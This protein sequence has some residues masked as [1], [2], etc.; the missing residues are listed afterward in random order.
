MQVAASDCKVRVN[1]FRKEL[2]KS[3]S[4]RQKPI[5]FSGSGVSQGYHLMASL[6]LFMLPPEI[7]CGLSL[8]MLRLRQTLAAGLACLMMA[9]CG[10]A[11]AVPGELP[12]LGDAAQDVLSPQMQRRLGESFYN[13][14]RLRDPAYIDDPEIT[15]YVSQVGRRLVSA[16]QNPSG[17]FTFFVLRDRQINAFATFGGYVGINTGLLLA[18]RTESE[19][20]GVLAHEISHVNQQHLARGI[21]AAK[22]QSISSLA[23]LALMILAVR[24]GQAGQ[25]AQGA[26]AAIEAANIQSQLGYSRDFEREADRVGFQTLSK[27]G[28]D[29]RGMADFFERLQKS[30]ALY[31]NNAPVYLR[32]HPLTTERI[33]DMQGRAQGAPYRQVRDSLDFYLVRAKLRTLEYA[34]QD[35]LAEFETQL[36][37]RRFVHEAAVWYGIARAQL[38]MGRLNEADKS[39]SH[40]RK[41]APP[42]SMFDVLAA[43]IRLAEKDVPGAV[44]IYRESYKR[45]PNDE[46]LALGLVQM[47]Q[48]QGQNESA[49]QIIETRLRAGARDPKLYQLQAQSYAALG[50]SVA[51]RRAT[52]E[53]YALNGQTQ[54]AVEQLELAQREAKSF[55]DQSMIDT[56]LKA[57]RAQVIE[58]RK[59]AGQSPF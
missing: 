36:N 10:L 13:E 4:L 20:A 15:A 51:S 37:E 18:A 41:L 55:Y 30:T 49:I 34:P 32:T 33:S 25:I 8:D 59:A 43:E 9:Q 23:S 40:A 56:R 58:E 26:S 57:L 16:S 44:N 5:R 39:L 22:N 7:R 46:A 47:L 11:V 38:R 42:E 31:E 50:K 6:Y 14:I 2:A 29:P 52:A 21:M 12:E 1:G 19:F 17:R 3:S 28:Y 48:L 54:A 27:A 53:A 35:A 45:Y 24:S